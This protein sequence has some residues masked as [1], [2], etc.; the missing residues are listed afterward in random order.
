MGVCILKCNTDSEKVLKESY[1]D[2]SKKTE[3]SIMANV[4][5]SNNLIAQEKNYEKK[6]FRKMFNDNKEKALRQ[7]NTEDIYLKNV[8][9]I[10]MFYRNHI[11]LKRLKQKKEKEKE[12]ELELQEKLKEKE[13]EEEESIS[14][15][16]NIE[17]VETFFSSNSLN[18]S[19][20]SKENLNNNNVNNN[21]TTNINNPNNINIVNTTEKTLNITMP[22]N[23]KK[24]LTTMPYKYSGY[25]KKKSKTINESKSRSKSNNSEENNNNI[26]NNIDNTEENLIKEGFGKFLFKDGSEFCG[27]FHNNIF[28]TYGK[29]LFLNNK[30]DNIIKE[31]EK[32]ILITDNNLNYEE[33]IGEYKNYIPDGFGI[34]KNLITNTKITGIFG[35]NGLFGIGSEYSEEEG[36]TYY[37]EF[38]NNKKDGIGTLIWKDGSKYQGQFINNRINGYGMMEFPGKKFY[39]GEMKNGKMDGYGQ[40]FWADKSK[41]IGYYKKD[42]RN[43]FGV[44]LS[45]TNESYIDPEFDNEFDLNNSTAYICYWKNGFMDGFGMVV[46]DKTIKYGIWDNGFKRKS[47][48]NNTNILSYAKWMNKRYNRLFIEKEQNIFEFLTIIC[49]INKEFE[50]ETSS[51]TS[52]E[53]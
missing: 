38:K 6:K 15:K 45:K 25:M 34:Y 27:I 44:Y 30:E 5:T 19:N 23:I 3:Q 32:E 24:K 36:Y 33:F 31:G 14:L 8:T 22:F 1:I 2:C 9:K 47:L 35:P 43:G 12:K 7:Q 20:I 52:S 53:K 41:Y 29:Y 21:N 13:K 51:Y 39:Q 42:K 4:I 37:G 50:F 17:M 46:H 18:N 16:M 10:Q 48:E 11:R 26:N 40:F 49:D 28:Q